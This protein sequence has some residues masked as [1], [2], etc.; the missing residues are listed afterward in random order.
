MQIVLGRGCRIAKRLPD[1][2]QVEIG[3]IHDDL[4][5]G[6][7]VGHEVHDVRNRDPAPVNERPPTMSLG[8]PARAGG[9]VAT[10]A[11]TPDPSR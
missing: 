3:Q 10:G 9:R 11:S 1:V 6:H 2:H 8:V 4:L 5:R 7:A